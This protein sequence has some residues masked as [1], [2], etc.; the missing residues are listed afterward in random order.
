MNNYSAEAECGVR[1]VYYID[2]T[3]DPEHETPFQD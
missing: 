1:A 2:V 3:D